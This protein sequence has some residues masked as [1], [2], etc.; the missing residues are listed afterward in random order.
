MRKIAPWNAFKPVK[1][2]LCEELNSK[3][4]RRCTNAYGLAKSLW[5]NLSKIEGR[6]SVGWRELTTNIS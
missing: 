4:L 3:G 2:P 5:I 6:L 1:R